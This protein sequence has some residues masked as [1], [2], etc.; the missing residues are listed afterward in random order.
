M[1]KVLS[2]ALVLMMLLGIMCV[3]P[4]S[5]GA[6]ETKTVYVGVISYIEDFV[7]E[8]HYWNND[9][10]LEGDAKLTCVNEMQSFLLDYEYWNG[11]AQTFMMYSAEIPVEATHMKTWDMDTDGK[12]AKEEVVAD[13]LQTCLL[14]EWDS[15]YHNVSVET[16][17]MLQLFPNG[18]RSEIGGE[19]PFRM[20]LPAGDLVE[21]D[22]FGGF[23]PTRVGYTL[24]GWNTK[25]DGSGEDVIWPFEM[26]AHSVDLYAVW[27]KD[28]SIDST[29]EAGYYLVGNLNGIDKWDVD[30]EASDRLFTQNPDNE[31][32]YL[33]DYTLVAGDEIKVAY[34]NG[35]CITELYKDENSDP[36]TISSSRAGEKTIHFMPDGNEEWAYNYFVVKDRG[37]VEPEEPEGSVKVYF[38]DYFVGFEEIY[39]YAWTTT[40][41]GDDIATELPGKKMTFTGMELSE[42]SMFAGSP[43]Y[44]VDFDKAYDYIRFTGM[45]NG[46]EAST[47]NLTFEE[48]KYLFWGTEL[49]YDSIADLEA[50][51]PAATPPPATDES[52]TVY[53]VDSAQFGTAYAYAYN[54]EM[55]YNSAWPG[56][57]MTLTDMVAPDGSPVYSYKSDKHYDYIIFN[58]GA[59]LQTADLVFTPDQ[60]LYWNDELWYESLD[61]IPSSGINMGNINIF[62]QNNWYWDNVNIY[63][64]G[65]ETG[66]NPA[67][68]GVSMN[69]YE[70]DGT[71]DI[72]NKTIPSDVDGFLFVDTDSFGYVEDQSPDITEGFYS[73]C[74]YYMIWDNG[75]KVGSEHI[76]EILSG[77]G[78][79]E[80]EPSDVEYEYVTIYFKN[81]WGWPDAKIY[82]WGSETV[83]DTPWPG[84]SMDFYGI[85]DEY[86]EEIFS[87]KLPVDVEG[88]IFTGTSTDT[89]ELDQSP[90]IT[91][92]F[93]EGICYHM[94]WSIEDGNLIGSGDISDERIEGIHDT[95]PEYDMI[96]FQNLLNWTDVKFYFFGSELVDLEGEDVPMEY[97]GFYGGYEIYRYYMPADV[98]GFEFI[99]T[100]ANGVVRDTVFVEGGFFDDLCYYPVEL[101]E[102]YLGRYENISELMPGSS[103]D[104]IPDEPEESYAD[105]KGYSITLEGTI[106]VNFFFDISED[107][108][109]EEGAVVRFEVPN[110]GETTIL[111][112]P[113]SQGV[114]D[115]NT[116]Y[117]KFTCYVAA[118]E[119][120]SVIKA[121]VI[122]SLA[123]TEVKEYTVKQYAEYMLEHSDVYAAEL[124]I[125]KALL[126]YGTAS[127]FYFDYN[128]DNLANDTELMTAEE[129]VIGHRNIDSFAPVIEGE[130]G[131]VV[132]YGAS[133]TLKSETSLNFYFRIDN[134]VSE[135]MTITVNG[136]YDA[137]LE[138]N[139]NLYQFTIENISA[140]QLGDVYVLETGGQTI[141]YSALSYAYTAQQSSNPE[142]VDVANALVAY[143]SAVSLYWGE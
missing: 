18:G 24:A 92:G 45:F 67:W 137:A 31:S 41:N 12:W 43:V 123:D 49:W 47:L 55:E 114:Y 125:V 52:E 130:A 63:F 1:K 134:P 32:E 69:Y 81:N 17:F 74:C 86:R 142:L 104:E 88:F 51:F 39:A 20:G 121:Q 34:Y 99:G 109:N 103:D 95:D 110:T 22:F 48:D 75:N 64:W 59:G 141:T 79:E 105:L 6:E 14:F 58:D 65:S 26:P 87:F 122:T 60:F 57:E 37:E 10:G 97:F 143:Y 46:T 50:S 96:Y 113:V 15:T 76:D 9:T 73:G 102:I 5:V 72:Y 132:Y 107:I 38:V 138:K 35:S 119:L 116:G 33:L 135:S 25:P 118:K 115:D 29:A 54:G 40:E 56:V 89:G 133:L 77:T 112:I 106:G 136:I 19:R 82:Y 66:E 108:L 53:Y 4:V 126:N 100:D 44:S 93:Y 129:K 71:Y 85:E 124:D 7:P 139:G 80:D 21:Q 16:M 90:D 11:E 117:Y 101:D 36:Y 91:E 94:R 62:F 2:F 70:N 8:I 84:V 128:T 42:N 127:Q 111:E 61:D 3:A 78:G 98:E 30:G 23:I 120:T 28:T 27:E 140:H 13:T 83:E 68:P 131:E